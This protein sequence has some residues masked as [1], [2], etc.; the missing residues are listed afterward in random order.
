M[1]DTL[2]RKLPRDAPFRADLKLFPKPHER[3]M[4]LDGSV[5]TESCVP[6]RALRAERG[7]NF[8]IINNPFFCF[9]VYNSEIIS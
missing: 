7:D 1:T 2:G 9:N 4:H 5:A 8:T 6:I 3:G